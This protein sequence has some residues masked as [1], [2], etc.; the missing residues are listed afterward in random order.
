[1][2]QAI[3]FIDSEGVTVCVPLASIKAVRR[4]KNALASVILDDGT[5]VHAKTRYD[6][7]S[8]EMRVSRS[9]RPLSH[10]I[11]ITVTTLYGSFPA[12]V[13]SK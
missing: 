12:K 9:R 13:S 8:R 5:T 6:I 1:M 4:N 2:A 7:L 10:S 11:D 3:E